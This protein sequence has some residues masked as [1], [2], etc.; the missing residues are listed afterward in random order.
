[1][2]EKKP[3]QSTTKHSVLSLFNLTWSSLLW[4]KQHER[5]WRQQERNMGLGSIQSFWN[6][7]AVLVWYEFFPLY[8]GI[9]CNLN[10]LFS[11]IF[12]SVIH[13]TLFYKYMY[14]Y[15]Y[16]WVFSIHFNTKFLSFC[17]ITKSFRRYIQLEIRARKIT[18]PAPY[19][20]K[21]TYPQGRELL[22]IQG[23]PSISK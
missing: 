22:Q 23:C 9:F 2:R 14:Q 10:Q 5:K 20:K 21:H 7:R 11:E 12:V 17:F 6:Q 19:K 18:D 3:I 8:F 16:K 15:I 1:M 13:C 4:R